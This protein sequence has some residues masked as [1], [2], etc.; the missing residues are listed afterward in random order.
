MTDTRVL[1]LTD[2]LSIPR[3]KPEKASSSEVWS[4]RLSSSLK[5]RAD[6]L[7]Y[8]ATGLHTS[9]LMSNLEN[10]LG[11]FE[12]DIIVAQVG[13]VDCSPRTMK[14]NERKV[15]ARLPQLVRKPLLN[16]IRRNYDEIIR[17]RNIAYVSPEQFEQNWR[18][19]KDYFQGCEFIIIPIAPASRGY[20]Q[21]N[22]LIEQNILAYNEILS[23][24]FGGS[25]FEAAYQG[26]DTEQLF[27]SDNHH[28]SRSGHAF[29]LERLQEELS[30]RLEARR[31]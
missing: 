8:T 27:M 17:R 15:V 3:L 5:D 21:K 23:R 28:L 10:Q 2:S 7:F 31:G 16:F 18:K 11:A 13:I 24:V 1:L 22:P 12:P 9:A 4:Y 14:E 6:F 19:L 29:L 30:R 20:T 25:Y 26:A